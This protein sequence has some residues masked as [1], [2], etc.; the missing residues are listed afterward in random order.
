MHGDTRHKGIDI[1]KVYGYGA[2][3]TGTSFIVDLTSTQHD[4]WMHLEDNTIQG[5]ESCAITEQWDTHD[6]F[7]NTIQSNDGDGI[8]EAGGLYGVIAENIIFDNG[9]E[10]VTLSGGTNTIVTNNRFGNLTSAGTLSGGTGEFIGNAM[11]SLRVTPLTNSGGTWNVDGVV[12]G[13]PTRFMPTSLG[14]SFFDSGANTSGIFGNVGYVFR[15]NE[16]A[17]PFI[18]TITAL[19]ANIATGDENTIGVGRDP[20]TND[21]AYFGLHHI[22]PGST[23]NY[24]FFSLYGGGELFSWWPNGHVGVGYVNSTGEPPDQFDV[25]G[26]SGAAGF[27]SRGTKFT[28]SG[29]SISSTTG[30]ATA[31]TFTLG[32]NSCT[33]ILTMNGATGLTAPNGWTCQAHDRTAP[34]ILIGGESSSTTT[35]ASITIPAGAGSTDIISF[36]CEGY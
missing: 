30:G 21:V 11:G 34:T 20:S 31:G 15:N 7:R 25:I 12:G 10:G 36:S 5:M 18:N 2:Y 17:T 3:I 14:T 27:I 29:C 19:A 6:I 8:C 4:D 35:T 23:S 32:A 33:A 1:S 24:G 22:S 28:T 9:G 13:V 26:G 16:A